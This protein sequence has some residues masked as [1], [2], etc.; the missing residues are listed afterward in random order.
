MPNIGHWYPR[1]RIASGRFD[2]DQRGILDASHLRFFSRRSFVRAA[3]SA[4]LVPIGRSHNGL[5]LD[6]LR[7]EN[8][9]A[10]SRLIGQ[11]DRALVTVWP[12]LFAYQF[13]FEFV[14]A[15]VAVRSEPA[16]LH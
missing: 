14:P 4:G 16:N 9:R 7:L 6:A 11:L 5:P 2:Y 13:V 10:V 15:H 3:E 12:T 1:T 8:S